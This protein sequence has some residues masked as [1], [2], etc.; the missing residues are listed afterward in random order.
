MLGRGL[1]GLYNRENMSVHTSFQAALEAGRVAIRTGDT[2]EALEHFEQACALAGSAAETAESQ[3]MLG[4]AYAEL[5]E[6]RQ[7]EDLLHGALQCAAGLPD[8]LARVRQR[9]GL[10]AWLRGEMKVARE[11]LRQAEADFRRLGMVHEHSQTLNNLGLVLYDM[12]E[13]Q[14]AIDVYEQALEICTNLNVLTDVITICGNLGECYY[15]LGQLERAR[16]LFERGLALAEQ[17][18]R[19]AMGIDRLRN[20]GRVQAQ[21]GDLDQALATIERAATLAETYHRRDVYLQARCSLAEVWL[22]RGEAA[23]AEAI[24]REL[25]PQL[26]EETTRRAEV[27]LILGQCGLARGDSALALAVLQA[28]LLDAQRSFS[29]I[30]ILRY[31]AML[32]QMVDHPAIAQVHRRI[33]AELA[34]Q[35]ADALHDKT[36]RESFRQLP[37]I[38]AVLDA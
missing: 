17:I 38:R 10:V 37:L 4:Y 14:H 20:L 19:P 13:Y 28:G 1:K 5:G 16:A 34:Q 31:H 12:G 2:R 26:V 21:T 24:A 23:R 8:V 3:A 27:Q 32:S 33:A 7:A 25:L 11:F 15:D 29:A 18:E 22:L 36:F 30:L 9:A 35:I 6:Y